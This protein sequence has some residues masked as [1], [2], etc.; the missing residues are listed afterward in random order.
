MKQQPILPRVAEGSD[1]AMEELM[2]RYGRVVRWMARQKG[3]ADV[4]DATQEVF[5]ALWQN[6]D[7]YDPKKGAETTFVGTVARRKMIDRH[8]K[9]SR[10]PTTD[11]IDAVPSKVLEFPSNI[12]QL[13]DAALASR[14]MQSLRPIQRSVIT[15]SLLEGLSHSEIAGRLHLPLG[16]VK[17]HMRRGLIELRELLSVGAQEAAVAA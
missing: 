5:I 14:A 15:L 2:Q 9:R 12:E 4:E 3:V 10:R 17:T 7:K 13:T 1:S 6:A 8:R 16:S 11:E